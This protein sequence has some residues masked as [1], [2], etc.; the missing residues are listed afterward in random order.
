[1]DLALTGRS[2]LITGG[3]KGSGFATAW[4]L[5]REGCDVHIAART[6]TDLDKA[7]ATISA[8]FNVAVSIHVADLS[9]GDVARTLI[10]ACPD[11]DIL[12]NNAGAIPAG[13]IHA[14][15]EPR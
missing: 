4:S 2:A 10:D 12:V 5:A 11:I 15:D 1:M 13:D 14:I 8:R 3:S 6:R 9:H 7:K